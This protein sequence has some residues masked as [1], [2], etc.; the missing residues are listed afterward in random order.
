MRLKDCTTDVF[1]KSDNMLPVHVNMIHMESKAT[2]CA[3]KGRVPAPL[4]R[5]GRT[6]ICNG[7][8]AV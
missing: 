8:S 2:G 5:I 3:I 4:P 7:M 1:P 6:R